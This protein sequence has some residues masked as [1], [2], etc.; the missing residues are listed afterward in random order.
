MFKFRMLDFKRSS[1]EVQLFTFSMFQIKSAMKCNDLLY[2]QAL[3]K[4]SQPFNKLNIKY[5]LNL[6]FL[7]LDLKFISPGSHNYW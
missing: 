2:G 6:H 5:K 1:P 3:G 4:I 7:I